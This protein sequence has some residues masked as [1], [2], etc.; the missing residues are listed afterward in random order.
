MD[1]LR[2]GVAVQILVLA[3]GT[4]AACSTV[5][6]TQSVHSNGA[7]AG[8]VTAIPPVTVIPPGYT[9]PPAT[10]PARENCQS[11]SVTLDRCPCPETTSPVCLY[12]GAMLTVV[13]DKSQGGPGVPG[14]W[15]VPPFAQ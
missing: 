9:V 1:R 2:R 15:G 11:G 4:L 14:P 7:N 12:D 5:R 10:L 3:A 8:S 13:F 6:A